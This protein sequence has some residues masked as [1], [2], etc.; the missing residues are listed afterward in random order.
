[1]KAHIVSLGCPKNLTDT[2]S[3]MAK[4]VQEGYSFTDKPA[5]ADLIL[6]NTCAFIQSA[7]K[8]SIDTIKRLAKYKKQLVVAG[9]LPQRYKNELPKLLPQVDAF[10]GTPTKF[11]K[12][13]IKAT[14][15]WLAYVKIAE[16]C[17]NC[18]SYCTIPS[19]RGSLKIRPIKDVLNEVK[20]VA[21]TGVKEIIFVAQDTAAYPNFP[22][23]LQKTA[24]IKGVRWIRIL[25]AY[26][27]HITDRLLDVMAREKKIVKYIDL[28]IQHCND[29]I[30]KLMNRRYTRQDLKILISKV[31]RRKIA[32]R[33][34][35]IVGFP[36]EGECEFQELS[37][38]IK[39]V[40][41]DRLGI[42]TYSREEGTPASKMKG[43]QGS[44]KRFHKLMRVQAR[45]S[46]G[47]NKKL[48][49]KTLAA[50]IE[51]EVRG[52]F[53]GRTYMDAPDID[54][55]VFVRSSRILTPGELVKVRV[56][57]AKTYDLVGC[58]A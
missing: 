8:E 20:L 43:Q 33:T 13:A 58:L 46:K 4:L 53:I 38:F 12:K 31:R 24:R 52:G 1:M 23:L 11:S 56:T 51:R 26:P 41:F 9:C 28:P 37:D 25:Y 10:I 2:E 39:E 5:K 17:N 18:C 29:K 32:L 45:I 27:T 35:L 48:I 49:G 19:I 36:G 15:P 34:S 7:T 57:G 40:K 22:A 30:L 42:F 14:S 21:K 55:S 44:G 16:G 54:G 6:V 47:L 3:I 50:I